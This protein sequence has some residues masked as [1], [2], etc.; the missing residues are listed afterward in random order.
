MKGT[1][2]AFGLALPEGPFPR[3]DGA[4]LFVQIAKGEVSQLRDGR[5]ETVAH[6]GGAPHS[7]IEGAD[8]SLYVTQSGAVRI[9]SHQTAEPRP[10]GIQVVH[11]DGTI[12]HLVTEVDGR[13]LVA[14]NDLCFGPDQRLYFTD[15][16]GSFEPGASYQ[17]ARILCD[18][19]NRSRGD[20]C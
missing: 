20:D 10:P 7:V 9:G 1:R 5:V 4:L 17:R 14:P 6:V 18:R 12:S 3:R 19:S 8:G 11:P 15:T 2:V 13:P 16:G